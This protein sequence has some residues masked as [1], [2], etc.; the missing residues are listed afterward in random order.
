MF[1]T[2]IICMTKNTFKDCLQSI[3]NGTIHSN[4]IK[5][6]GRTFEPLSNKLNRTIFTWMNMYITYIF[7]LI[8]KAGKSTFLDVDIDRPFDQKEN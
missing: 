3:P 7:V 2:F 1:C 8:D 6:I 5:M 4:C